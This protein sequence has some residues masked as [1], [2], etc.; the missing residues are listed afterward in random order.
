MYTYYLF[1]FH[2]DDDVRRGSKVCQLHVKEACEQ[3]WKVLPS[4]NHG[5][6]DPIVLNVDNYLYVIGGGDDELSCERRKHGSQEG[7]PWET[8]KPLPEALDD[9]LGGGG[10]VINNTINIFTSKYFMIYSTQNN[11][12]PKREYKKENFICCTPALTPNGEIYASVTR[13][14]HLGLGPPVTTVEKYDCSNNVWTVVYDSC[15]LQSGAG[16]F[17]VLKY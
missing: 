3:E 16:R 17:F 10:V 5:R 6:Y 15:K 11:N 2:Q 8:I 13:D 14:H 7:D 9:Y 1:F 12:W 4:L